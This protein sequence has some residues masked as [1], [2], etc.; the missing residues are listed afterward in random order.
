MSGFLTPADMAILTGIKTGKRGK[1]REQLQCEFLR[2]KGIPFIPNAKGFPVVSWA[3]V[4]GYRSIP[5]AANQGW[6]PNVLKQP[7]A[8]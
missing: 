5:E 8:A 3:A 7:K 4:D 6:Q 1:T 2:T